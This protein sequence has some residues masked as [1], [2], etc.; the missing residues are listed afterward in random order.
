[1]SNFFILFDT[2]YLHDV[3]IG[4][5]MKIEKIKKCCRLMKKESTKSKPSAFVFPCVRYFSVHIKHK[6]YTRL[7][8]LRLISLACK[9]SDD[10]FT[11]IIIII[12]INVNKPLFFLQYYAYYVIW[13]FKQ[14]L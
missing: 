11:I 4:K 6:T 7:L 8:S 13:T 14:Y 1:M 5:K 2:K 3:I 9:F 12:I 10:V